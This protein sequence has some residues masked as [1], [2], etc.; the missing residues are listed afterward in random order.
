MKSII[1]PG[2]KPL[3][4]VPEARKLLGSDCRRM[5]DDQ[6]QEVIITLTLLARE[7]LKTNSSNNSFGTDIIE[8]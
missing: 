1:I 2:Y 6:V 5:N 7:F 3:I 8:S 4:T